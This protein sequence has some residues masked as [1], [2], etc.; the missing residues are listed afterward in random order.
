MLSCSSRGEASYRWIP[1]VCGQLA[2]VPVL[3]LAPLQGANTQGLH[4]AAVSRR[5]GK[6][7]VLAPILL[8]GDGLGASLSVFLKDQVLREGVGCSLLSFPP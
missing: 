2:H 3:S 7:L 1:G 5:E 6:A 8:L 4:G